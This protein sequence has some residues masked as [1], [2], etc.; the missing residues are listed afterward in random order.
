MWMRRE[1][2]CQY[3]FPYK[4]T[5]ALVA[6]TPNIA[7]R[8][9][10]R[11]QTTQMPNIGALGVFAYLVQSEWRMLAPVKLPHTVQIACMKTKTVC[12]LT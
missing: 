9:I 2:G 4:L 11:V 7:V 12:L 1:I 10:A 6:K 8:V 3:A 5:V